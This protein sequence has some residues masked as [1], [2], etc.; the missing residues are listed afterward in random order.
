[1]VLYER[2][3]ISLVHAKCDYR[4][5]VYL[6][7]FQIIFLSLYEYALANF[8]DFKIT[9]LFIID[10]TSMSTSNILLTVYLELESLECE[11]ED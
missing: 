3:S 11:C 8:Y 4:C 6:K 1:M 5:K 10:F 9:K 2:P 7:Y